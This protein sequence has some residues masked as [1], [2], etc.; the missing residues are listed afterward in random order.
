MESQKSAI[1]SLYAAVSGWDAMELPDGIPES[2]SLWDK[3]R[4]MA[5]KTGMVKGKDTRMK[6]FWQ[7]NCHFASLFNDFLFGGRKVLKADQ[8][9]EMDTDVSGIINLN[10]YEKEVKR[11]R[12][13][14]KKAAYGIEFV[15]AAIENQD[16]IHYA[17]PLRMELY[18]VLSAPEKQASRM[19]SFSP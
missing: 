8:L 9:Q 7:D 3:E 12:D 19:S 16:R 18:D 15:V 2:F 11:I 14:V 17:M 1:F 13:I 5:K 6:S 10:G 4:N